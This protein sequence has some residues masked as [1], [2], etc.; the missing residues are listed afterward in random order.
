MMAGHPNETSAVGLRNV[1]FALQVGAGDGGFKRNAVAAEWEK[2]L[3]DL[4]AGDAGGYE[5]FVAIRKGKGHWMD[6]EDKVAVPWMAKF[7]RRRMPYRIVWK[8]DDRTHSRSYWLAIPEGE[9]KA[10]QLV[11]A[12]RDGQVITIEKAE[13]VGAV[14]I[15]LNDEMVD[16][17]LPV[18]VVMDRETLFEGKVERSAEVIERTLG[19]RL[20]PG[21]VFSG[22]VKVLLGE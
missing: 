5:H 14:T 3:A 1:P 6:L 9:V 19:E 15:L 2:K 21:L 8:Q 18:T 12:K 7:D 22:E 4:R 13:D 16:L 10:R 11:V 17:D 20:D